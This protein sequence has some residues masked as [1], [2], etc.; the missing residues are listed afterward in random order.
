MAPYDANSNSIMSFI[1]PSS[2]LILFLFNRL[3]YD[4]EYIYLSQLKVLDQLPPLLL[5]EGLGGGNL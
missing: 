4:Y 1:F 2:Q 3:L 5:E